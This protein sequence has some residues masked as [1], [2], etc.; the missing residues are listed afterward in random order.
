MDATKVGEI[1]EMNKKGEIPANLEDLAIKLEAKV[2]E[3][4]GSAD[5]LRRIGS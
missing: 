2:E 3:Q 5:D 4:Q 1:I